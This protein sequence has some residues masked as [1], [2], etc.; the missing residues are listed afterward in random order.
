MYICIY[1]YVV[2]GHLYEFIMVGVSNVSLPDELVPFW[3]AFGSVSWGF[4]LIWT[5]W[6][7][8]SSRKSEHYV[9]SSCV[10]TGS[11]VTQSVSKTS[12]LSYPG[13]TPGAPGFTLARC[14]GKKGGEKRAEAFSGFTFWSDSAMKFWSCDDVGITRLNPEKYRDRTIAHGPGTLAKRPHPFVYSRPRARIVTSYQ[15]NFKWDMS[16]VGYTVT[17]KKMS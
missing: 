13:N 7:D 16:P 11:P 1:I 2:S 8:L 5:D 6:A 17:T 14:G 9:W 15:S 3:D 10:K 12:N 4:T